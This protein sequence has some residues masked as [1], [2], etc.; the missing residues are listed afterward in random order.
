MSAGLN[1]VLKMLPL[2]A[3]VAVTAFQVPLPGSDV[4]SPNTEDRDVI[5]TV[6]LGC[7]KH[8]KWLM[9]EW[10]AK[11]FVVLRTQLR[12]PVR[13]NYSEL[14]K[15][16]IKYARIDLEDRKNGRFTFNHFPMSQEDL[17]QLLDLQ[18]KNPELATYQEPPVRPLKS[19]AW[20]KHILLTD[21]LPSQNKAD[22]KLRGVG[23]FA[24]VNLPA[25]SNNGDNCLLDVSI[26][27]PWITS[28]NFFAAS[29]TFILTRT[30]SGWKVVST[31]RSLPL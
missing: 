14:L 7:Y 10:N 3:S 20:D 11:T 9:P 6:L 26:P 27:Y 31:D 30:P 13:R 1:L 15:R 25:L 16:E 23:A 28:D 4:Q 24:S 19:Y 17:T 2:A 8:E 5:Q 22:R 18:R 21:R 12:S 29:I